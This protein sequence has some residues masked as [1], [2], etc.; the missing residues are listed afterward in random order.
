MLYSRNPPQK[1]IGSGG[2]RQRI[3]TLMDSNLRSS[4]VIGASA[5]VVIGNAAIPL[6]ERTLYDWNDVLKKFL[7]YRKNFVNRK[8]WWRRAADETALKMLAAVDEF[9]KYFLRDAAGEVSRWLGFHDAPSAAGGAHWQVGL[10]WH[11][12]G[13]GAIWG[14]IGRR[15]CIGR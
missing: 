3:L 9:E 7:E 5:A 13:N 1:L 10:Y 4:Y 12:T 11:G 8:K 2:P 15:G 6:V 14:C